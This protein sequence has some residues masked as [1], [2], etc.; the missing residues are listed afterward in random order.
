MALLAQRPAKEMRSSTRFHANQSSVHVGCETKQLDP[1]ELL[2]DDNLAGLV[3]TYQV[4]D[5]LAKID[6]DDVQVPGTPPRSP[7]YPDLE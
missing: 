5:R 7:L 3:Q 1:R 6:A 4:K 2:P